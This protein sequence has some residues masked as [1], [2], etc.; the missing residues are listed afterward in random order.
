MEP[1][2][3]QGPRFIAG[4]GAGHQ[5]VRLH[6]HVGGPSASYSPATASPVNQRRFLKPHRLSGTDTSHPFLPLRSSHREPPES[7]TLTALA[8]APVAGSGR[9][10]PKQLVAA[11]SLKLFC[12]PFSCLRAWLVL[13]VGTPDTRALSS[14][15]RI[16]PR[17]PSQEPLSSLDLFM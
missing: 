17:E 15:G 8:R 14:K 7:C 3:L 4:P 13:P 10:G 9:T 6:R 5:E 16:H 11:R 12:S 2:V 1:R